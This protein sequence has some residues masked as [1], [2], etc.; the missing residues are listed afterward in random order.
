MR[1]MAN[2]NEECVDIIDGAGR[3]IGAVTRQEMRRR[4]L[5]HRCTY[6]LVFDGAG[7]LFIHLRTA[8]KDVFPSHWDV[9]VGGVLLSGETFAQGAHRE[10]RE[11]LGVDAIP[12][13]LFPF[14]YEDA[15]TVVEATVYRLI[16]GGPFQLQA[17]EIVRGEFAT[18]SEAWAR[19]RGTLF[20]PDGLAVL[21]EYE[22]R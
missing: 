8:T 19:S 16:H 21:R 9:A 1:R 20:C 10:V 22:R 13:E 15:A 4:R 7:R 12:Q 5:P 11:E 3:T 17:E 18:V 2:A 6:V 14:R